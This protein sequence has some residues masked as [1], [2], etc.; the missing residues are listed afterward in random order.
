MELDLFGMKKAGEPFCVNYYTANASTAVTI[1]EGD[2]LRRIWIER[3]F[4]DAYEDEWI[5][6]LDGDNDFLGPFRIEKGIP[7]DKKF[8]RPVGC[9]EGKAL[10]L[11]T[12]NDFN[13][14]VII[15]GYVDEPTPSS[16][17]SAS[18]SPSPTG[19]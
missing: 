1:K 6:I 15:E 17:V 12:Q 4:I 19:P 16:S 11:Q 3:I 14:L 5:K 2:P 10:K 13:V 7:L 9:T 18:P 8:L